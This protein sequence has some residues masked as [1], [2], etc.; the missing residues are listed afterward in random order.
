MIQTLAKYAFHQ[1]VNMPY[2]VQKMGH[3]FTMI[4][5]KC[6]LKTFKNNN[7]QG[8]MDANGNMGIKNSLKL[9]QLI[10]QADSFFGKYDNITNICI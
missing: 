9:Q 7:L 8:S 1:I 3:W 5:L 4:F 10:N 6:K 2:L